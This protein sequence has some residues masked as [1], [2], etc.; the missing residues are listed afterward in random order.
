MTEEVVKEK[1]PVGVVFIGGK[2]FIHGIPA[3][4]LTLAE[5]NKLPKNKQKHLLKLG[6]YEVKYD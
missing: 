1:K 5:W 3:R 6:L 4:D 2:R